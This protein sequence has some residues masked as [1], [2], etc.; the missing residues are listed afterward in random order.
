MAA[1]D[2]LEK[3]HG[4]LR[5]QAM[6]KIVEEAHNRG[7]EVFVVVG[8]SAK[9]MAL[10]FNHVWKALYPTEKLPKL[11]SL[12]RDMPILAKIK[13]KRIMLFDEMAAGGDTMSAAR[14][15]FEK[16]GAKN[17][18]TAVIAAGVPG[19]ADVVGLPWLSLR[20]REEIVFFKHRQF[21]QKK[22]RRSREAIR[23]HLKLKQIRKHLAELGAKAR[24][25][26]R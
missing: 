7:I 22:Y 21:L 9:P 2:V 15:L 4:K 12:R 6:Q 14:K 3:E 20:T 26:P 5:L 19:I 23:A 24:K 18:T 1:E 16:I 13:D 17:I 11:V 25:K 10:L 8:A